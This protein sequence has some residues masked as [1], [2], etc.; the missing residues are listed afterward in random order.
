MDD[1]VADFDAALHPIGHAGIMGDHD[2]CRAG[3]LHHGSQQLHDF[4]ARGLVEC[5]GR[6]IG[7]DD[8]WGGHQRTRN[9]DALGLAA[10]D[11]PWATVH[12]GAK[13]QL[14]EQFL[15][16]RTCFRARG[17]VEHRWQRYIIERAE[18]WQ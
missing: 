14:V 11:L 17:S 6:F 5:T 13:A 9:R 10:R 16:F 1:A 3:A 12:H 15:C 7:E 8:C 4:M 2:Q 18:L